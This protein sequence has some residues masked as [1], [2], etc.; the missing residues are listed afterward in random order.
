MKKIIYFFLV[1]IFVIQACYQDMD[2]EP[3][4]NY[5]ESS[6]EPTGEHES[7]KPVSY[8]HLDVYKRQ[9][10]PYVKTIMEIYGAEVLEL[11]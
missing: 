11:V 8:T 10:L 7:L 6:S 4:F 1:S 3:D 9:I 2:N 5:P